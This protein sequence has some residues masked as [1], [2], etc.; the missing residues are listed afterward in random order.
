[1]ARVRKL[2][3]D[4][5]REIAEHERQDALALQAFGPPE[6]PPLP[7]PG[8]AV[9]RLVEARVG[10]LLALALDEGELR[11]VLLRV[12]SEGERW[13]AA[14]L[15][16]DG[17]R[18]W[19]SRGRIVANLGRPRGISRIDHPARRTHGWFVRIYAQGRARVAR[20][21]SDG[22]YGGVS[23]ALEAALAFHESQERE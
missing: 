4:E 8:D 13:T 2:T 19:L 23:E 3:P 22:R 14:Q 12:Q 9:E 11:G 15:L 1:V 17:Q 18:R 6:A 21:F 5:L 16:C 10:D 20:L 7:R